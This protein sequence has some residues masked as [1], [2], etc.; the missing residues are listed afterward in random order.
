MIADKVMQLENH[1]DKVQ[2]RIRGGCEIHP[3]S[4]TRR[5]SRQLFELGSAATFCLSKISRLF[6]RAHDRS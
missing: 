4:S 1:Y 3:V 5:E 6:V 2:R